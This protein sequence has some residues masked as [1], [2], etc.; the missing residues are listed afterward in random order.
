MTKRIFP[1]CSE[2]YNSSMALVHIHNSNSPAHRSTAD[3]KAETVG[4]R[5]QG[6]LP[7]GRVTS[8]SA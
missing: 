2:A 6:I 8:L 3:R 4:W 5:C 1:G 7:L